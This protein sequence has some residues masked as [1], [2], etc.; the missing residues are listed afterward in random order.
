MNK[1]KSAKN[2]MYTQQRTEKNLMSANQV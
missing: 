2:G 1:N